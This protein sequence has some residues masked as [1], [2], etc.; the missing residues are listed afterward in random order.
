[1]LILRAV[2]LFPRPLLFIERRIAPGRAALGPAF[3]GDLGDLLGL[4]VLVGCHRRSPRQAAFEA[5]GFAA[6]DMLAAHQVLAECPRRVLCRCAFF[7]AARLAG[8]GSLMGRSRPEG[9]AAAEFGSDA[10]RQPRAL[11]ILPRPSRAFSTENGTK[12]KRS[13]SVLFASSLLGSGLPL[14]VAKRQERDQIVGR[15]ADQVGHV[16]KSPNSAASN[17]T[18]QAALSASWLSAIR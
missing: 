13:A 3:A 7:F 5:G 12:P 1:M 10:E 2:G 18:S 14:L 17:F 16:G 9:F 11:A 6:D 4:F 15:K 8:S